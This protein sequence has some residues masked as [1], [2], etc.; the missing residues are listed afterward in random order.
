MA[1]ARKNKSMKRSSKSNRRSKKNMSGGGG[2][3]SRM[4]RSDVDIFYDQVKAEHPD[5]T[6][7][8]VMNEVE[9]LLMAFLKEKQ[10]KEDRDAGRGFI[11]NDFGY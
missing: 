1:V 3:V 5:W 10:I 11:H 9:K 4:M 2:F 7:K 8:E 6:Q